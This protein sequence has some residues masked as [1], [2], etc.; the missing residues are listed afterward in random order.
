[1]SSLTDQ[2]AAH[3]HLDAR[4]VDHLQR[5]V[6]QWQLLADLSFADLLL[7]V[8]ED[9]GQYL[10]V[11]Q[12]RPTTGPTAHVADRVGH[13][14][15]GAR[16]AALRTAVE[17]KRI[18][19][20]S[21]PEWSDD[22]AVRHEAIPVLFDGAVVAVL[23]R[24]S[25][26][27]M[28]R[29]PSPLELAYLQSAADLAAMVADGTFPGPWPEPEGTALPRVGDGLLRL[30]RSTDVLYASPNA[31]SA[32]RR[33]GAVGE[34]V[35]QPFAAVLGSALRDPLHAGYL[36]E[37]VEAAVEGVH[38]GGQEVDGGGATVLFQPLPL[39]PRG[40]RLG[41]LVLLQDVTELRRRDRQIMSKDA[42]I[43]EIHHRVKNNLQ[44]VAALLRMQARRVSAPQARTALEEAMRRV[45]AIALV[46]ETLSVTDEDAVA[47]DGVLDRLMGVLAEVTGA[48]TRVELRR[49][50]SFGDLN[51]DVATALVMVLAELIQNAVEHGFEGEEHGTVEVSAARDRTRLAVAVID[52]GRGLPE[53]FNPARSD[54]LGLQIVRTLA[55]A[56]LH[57]Q[58]QWR[59]RAGPASGTIV[60]LEVELAGLG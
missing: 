58:V 53:N 38:A 9:D 60:T 30:D 7:W 47:F 28:V 34:V 20:E 13:R 48:G 8:A 26:L 32:L 59:P 24:D 31:L 42:T 54:R 17:E 49:S 41:A 37:R 39:T 11:A 2:L 21:D 12:C 15:D 50:G 4:A 25:N 16:A 18:F 44:T 43:R 46:H 19:R 23:A 57:T 36:V 6:G 27:T 1:M 29:G 3:T 55:D 52:D 5:L 14:R 10:C 35:G 33:L 40:E 22:L 51:A 45:S 56:E